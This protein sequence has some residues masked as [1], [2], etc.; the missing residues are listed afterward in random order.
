M[1]RLAVYRVDD[2]GRSC[3]AGGDAA[4]DPGFGAVGVDD[5]E[6][7]LREQFLQG[8]VRFEVIDRIQFANK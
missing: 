1:K 8:A 4:D 5:V 2:D 6:F 3:P 7:P